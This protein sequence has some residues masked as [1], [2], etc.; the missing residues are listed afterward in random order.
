MGSRFTEN[1]VIL[2]VYAP[3][4][5]KKECEKEQIRR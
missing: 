5:L 1:L 3:P 2:N 4:L